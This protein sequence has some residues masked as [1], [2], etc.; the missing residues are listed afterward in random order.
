MQENNISL[1]QQAG[2]KYLLQILKWTNLNNLK[3]KTEALNV[4]IKTDNL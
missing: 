2:A 4:S 1:S 3:L